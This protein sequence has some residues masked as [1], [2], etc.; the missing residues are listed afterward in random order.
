MPMLAVAAA[1][2][3]AA[4]ALSYRGSL[5]VVNEI[6]PQEKRAEMVSSSLMVCYLG[7]AIPVLGVG[8]LA[9][10]LSAPTA[11]VL[12]AIVVA[13][14]AVTAIFTGMVGR[15]RERQRQQLRLTVS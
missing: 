13:G 1:V 8:L 14:L 6:A 10:D 12:F 15:K 7:N 11:H 3:G 4:M 2:G 5:Q 9:T